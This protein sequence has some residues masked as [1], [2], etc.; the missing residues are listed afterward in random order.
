MEEGHGSSKLPGRI[1]R[2]LNRK[3]QK[4]LINNF[5]MNQFFKGAKERVAFGEREGW[6]PPGFIAISPTMRCNLRCEGCW[7]GKFDKTDEIG[8]EVFDRVINEAKE[9]GIYFF[10]VTG[11]EPFFD[12]GIFELFKKHPDVVFHVYTNGTLLNEKKVKVLAELGNVS[13]VI[14]LEGFQEKTD[15]RRGK[16]IFNKVLKA[17]ELLSKYGVP[18]GFATT[19]T[20][21]NVDEVINGKFIELMVEKGCLFAWYFHY[22]PVGEKPDIDLMPSPA[23]R[24]Q[25]RKGVIDLRKKYPI[26]LIDFHNDS[27]VIGGCMSAGKRYVH[28]NAKG[29]VEPCVFVHFASDN[30]KNKSLKEALNSTF[31]KNLRAEISQNSNLLKPCLIVDKTEVIKKAVRETGSKSTLAGAELIFTD[32]SKKLTKYQDEYSE[33][34]DNVWEEEYATYR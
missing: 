10:N 33:I 8:F 29:D 23:Q 11:G 32:F 34:I 21:N 15:S 19:V 31:M 14:S 25:V 26:V 5:I 27:P 24:E 9:M 1:A 3:C 7:A 30:V 18:H 28:I 2:E 12:D 6:L 4:K 17:M 16:G 20:R 13:P 22:M